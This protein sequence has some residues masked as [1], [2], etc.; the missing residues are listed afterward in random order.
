MDAINPHNKDIDTSV[1]GG[2]DI[3]I[4]FNEE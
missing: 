1:D 4:V 2:I 3:G